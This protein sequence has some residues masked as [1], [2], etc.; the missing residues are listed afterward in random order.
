MKLPYNPLQTSAKGIKAACVYMGK[1][2]KNWMLVA[3]C[4]NEIFHFY[5]LWLPT[6]KI[7]NKDNAVVNV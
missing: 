5:Y 2:N 4:M 7:V 6:F 3:T 1:M